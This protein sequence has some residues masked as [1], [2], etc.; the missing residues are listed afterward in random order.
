[1]LVPVCQ[2][3]KL[4]NILHLVQAINQDTFLSLDIQLKKMTQAYVDF[5]PFLS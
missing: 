2:L 5:L 3:G 1:M 4:Q